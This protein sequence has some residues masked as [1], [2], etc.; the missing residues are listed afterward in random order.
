VGIETPN[1]GSLLECGKNHNRNRDLLASVKKIHNHGMQVQGGFIVGFDS[2]PASIFENQIDFIQKSGIVTA[3]VGLLS[4]FPETKLYSRLKGEKRLLTEA[5]GDN[6]DCSVNFIPKMKYEALV[7][8]YRKVINTIYSPKH[9]YERVM[10]FLK[11]YKPM[12]RGTFRPS[13]RI[14]KGA[15][16]SVWV[17]GIVDKGRKYFWKLFFATMLKHPRSLGISMTFAVCGFHFRK[18]ADIYSKAL[19]TAQ[20]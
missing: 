1:D 11:D 7:N 20:R 14:L 15:V 5:S 2:D 17:L 19:V 6:T 10:A 16:K 3:M 4:A 8:G 9:Y 13:L 18:I 12:R